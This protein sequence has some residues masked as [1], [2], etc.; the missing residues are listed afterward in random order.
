LRR[1]LAEHTYGHR[2]RELESIL[3]AL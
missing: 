2:A 3:R 1:I